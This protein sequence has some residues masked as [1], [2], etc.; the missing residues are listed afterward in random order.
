MFGILDVLCHDYDAKTQEL[1]LQTA[2]L[3]ESVLKVCVCY[4]L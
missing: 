1:A 2:A 3:L 4:N